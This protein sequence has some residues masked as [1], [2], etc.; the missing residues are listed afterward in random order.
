[1][2]SIKT[3]RGLPKDIHL[4]FLDEDKESNKK[5]DTHT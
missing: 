5:R 2:E 4:F 1:M 3:R